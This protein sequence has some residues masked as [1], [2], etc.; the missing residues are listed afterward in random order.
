MRGGAL[1]IAAELATS[2]RPRWIP[3]RWPRRGRS[4]L[5]R[6]P[7][8]HLPRLSGVRAR[9]RRGRA[10]AARR[11]GL[12]LGILRQAGGEAG[13]RGFERLPPE[14]RAL[15]LEPYLLNLTKANSR[16]TIHRPSYLDYVGVK[17]FDADGQGGRRAPLPR[18]LHAHRLPARARRHPDPAPQGRRGPRRAPPSRRQPQREG[19]GRDPR[20]LP[21][22]ELFQI[23]RGRADR[24]R[25]GHPP[26]RGAPAG[27]PLHPP[28]PLRPLL[29]L[30]R[31]RAARPL[32]HREQAAHRGHPARGGRR[33]ERRLH[34]ARLRVGARALALPRL[35][36]TRAGS[37]RRR[38]RVEN[39]IVA[40]TRSGPTTSRT[41]LSRSTGRSAAGQ[42]F[43]RYRHAFPRPT[44]PTGWR[45]RRS[46]TSS[47]S[48]RCGE[49]QDLGIGLYR[50]LE[51]PRG[52]PL[53]ALQARARR[54]R[55][56]TCCRCSRTWGCRCA[57]NVPTRS[58]ARG[59]ARLDLRL[60][61]RLPRRRGARTR[62]ACRRRSRTPFSAPGAA[63]W[64]TTATT[65]SYSAP[66]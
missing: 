63:K 45:A 7:Q 29:Q 57:T 16:A 43:R 61:P 21:R 58:A 19:A 18:P 48:R 56:R 39:R 33:H 1:A 65:A 31:V 3:R 20:G 40:A 62:T 26:P 17:R 47:A 4:S 52:V 41:R 22:D 38:R 13:S 28:R 37:R 49:T 15:A 10:A 50:P 8:L 66:G 2:R 12:G 46:P 23:S 11:P 34:D 32:Q 59:R 44:A 54:W 55:S 42:L 14:V 27:A 24:H 51:A 60:R 9:D 53:Q 30:P 25:D 36:G 6:G 5:A 64:R 35:H